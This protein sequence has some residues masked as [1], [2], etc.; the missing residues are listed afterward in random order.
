MAF[1][2]EALEGPHKGESFLIKEGF[3]IGRSK[4]KIVLKRDSKVSSLHALVRKNKRGELSLLDLH[5]AN[6]IKLQGERVKKITLLVGVTFEIGRSVFRVVEREAPEAAT[7]PVK[8]EDLWLEQLL[9]EVPLLLGPHRAEP[10]SICAFQPAVV[11]EIQRGIQADKKIILGYGPRE[12]GA[13]TLDVELEEVSA[14]PQAFYLVPV[15]GGVEF[16]TQ[17]PKVVLL[18][19]K[20]TPSQLLQ[21]GDLIRMGQTLIK[22]GL[23]K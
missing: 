10:K 9:R 14:P 22:F 12:F 8:K 23:E 1:Y 4:G 5:S 13:D 7:E 21:V 15:D 2:I 20:S 18:N 19:E 16:R 17:H 3:E 6:G 11:L